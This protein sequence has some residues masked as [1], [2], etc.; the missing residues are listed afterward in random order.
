M[1]ILHLDASVRFEGSTSRQLSQFFIDKLREN[2]LSFE[3]DRL[4]LAET[5]PNHFGPVQTAAVYVSI[6]D[7][8]PEMK[9][10]LSESDA[11][12]AR[13]MAAD[14]LVCGVPLYNFGM[15]SAFKAFVDNVSRSGIT[16]E[17]TESGLVGRL[18]GKYMAFLTSAG[19][20]YREGAVFEGLDCLT[21]HIRTIF[22]FLGVPEPDLIK[23]HPTTFE[24]V[25]AKEKAI[26]EAEA[27]AAEV[28]ARWASELAS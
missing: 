26:A 20:N 8:T 1:R 12:A 14:A 22:G 21:P 18:A 25:E 15:P 13:V 24:G 17:Y 4:D 7:H 3:I 6:S 16:F 10:A 28:A 27:R 19:G 23:A 9:A 2:G 11:L 5:P